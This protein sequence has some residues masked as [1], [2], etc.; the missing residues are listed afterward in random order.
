MTFSNRNICLKKKIRAEGFTRKRN[1]C[2]SNERKKIFVQAENSPPPITSLMVRP[3]CVT[4]SRSQCISS[5]CLSTGLEPVEEFH[6]PTSG[7]TASNSSESEKRQSNRPASRLLVAQDWPGH[8]SYAQIQLMLT[9]TPYPLPKE[10]SLL[11]L[12][13]DQEACHP[14]WRS[15]NLTVWPISSHPTRRQV[16]L[17]RL[18]ATF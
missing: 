13:F 3:L 9:G 2:T 18:K 6:T 15:L 11:S 14:L 16:S 7:A 1:S 8:P 5:G 4:T 10:K 12:P 17:T